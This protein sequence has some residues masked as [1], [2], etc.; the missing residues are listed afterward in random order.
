MR[1]FFLF[2]FIICLN[3]TGGTIS[4]QHSDTIQSGKKINASDLNDEFNTIHAV[5]NGAID[6]DNILDGGV[7]SADLAAFSVVTSKIATAS[8]AYIKNSKIGC[9]TS[10]ADTTT[11]QIRLPCEVYMDGV[12]G[13]L[14]ATESVTLVGNEDLDTGSVIADTWYF[15]YVSIINGV[16]GFEISVTEPEIATTRKIGDST[17]KYIGSMRS[18]GG[19]GQIQGFSQDNNVYQ[20]STTTV[21]SSLSKTLTTT[22]TTRVFDIPGIFTNLYFQSSF[23]DSPPEECVVRLNDYVFIYNTGAAFDIYINPH[24]IP[25]FPPDF[26]VKT[27]FLDPVGTCSSLVISI[28]GYIEDAALHQ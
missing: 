18:T 3:A 14:T 10:S 8:S 22:S 12:R 1:L 13:T 16:L 7:A 2:L 6:T 11:T 19:A 9:M 28:K 21:I 5:I 20:F 26:S 27:K 4:R 23:G 24:P 25:I 15:I 17:R